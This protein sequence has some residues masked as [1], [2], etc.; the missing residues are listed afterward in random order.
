MTIK[1]VLEEH[2][3]R[4]RALAIETARLDIMVL[5]GHLLGKDKAWLL[6]HGSD[7]ASVQFSETMAVLVARRAGGEA[8]AYILG[9][10]EFFGH[11]FDVGPGVLI[12]RPE[13]E[14]LVEWVLETCAGHKLD[15]LDICTGSACIP[16]ALSFERPQ[17]KISAGDI[18]TK[19][20]LW[21]RMNAERL[22]PG[23]ITIRQSNLFAGFGSD[24]FDL[25]TANPPYVPGAETAERMREGWKE[26]GLALDGGADGLDI[27]REILRL[28]RNHLKPSGWLFLEFGDGQAEA[29]VE[30]SKDFAYVDISVRKD[31]AGLNRVLRAR[32]PEAMT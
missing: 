19:A 24:T 14:I 23:R 15:Y 1:D 3:N 6:A 30:L 7:S 8:V 25:I 27:I 20:I 2:T 18:S 28:A 4:L 9:Y 10:K 17:W 29:V 5:A 32:V 11:N 31:L 13:T 12:P 21:A 26:P 16:L 22:M